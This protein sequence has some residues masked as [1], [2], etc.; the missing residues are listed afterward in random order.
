MPR[1]AY[2]RATDF[3]KAKNLVHRATFFSCASCWTEAQTAIAASFVTD[4]GLPG[5]L[6]TGERRVR[7]RNA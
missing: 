2:S 6:R 4:A 1:P 5:S 7:R 3:V